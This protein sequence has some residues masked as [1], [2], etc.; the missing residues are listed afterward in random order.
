MYCPR[1]GQQAFDEVRFCSRCGLRLDGVTVLL[2]HDGAIAPPAPESQAS[3]ASARQ[4]GIRLGVKLIFASIVL[5]PIFFAIAITNKV[6][7]PAPLLV[8]LTVFLVGLLRLLY[9]VIFEEERALAKQRP[10]YMQPRPVNQNA[11][12]PAPPASIAASRRVN[13]ADMIHSP[14]ITE[15]TTNLLENKR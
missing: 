10:Q 4:K 13:T 1:C 2:D 14:S 8:P 3:G 5:S 7:S 6:D 9:S 11:A 15:N 12:L